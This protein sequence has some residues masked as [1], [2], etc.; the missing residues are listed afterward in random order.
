MLY[1]VHFLYFFLYGG[2]IVLQLNITISDTED[3]MSIKSLVIINRQQ[4]SHVYAVPREKID[5]SN[6]KSR[7]S[8]QS[9]ES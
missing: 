1:P 8:V 3:E 2:A 5:L 4:H 6:L 9:L 7:S